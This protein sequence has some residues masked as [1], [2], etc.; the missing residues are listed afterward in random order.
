PQL[1]RQRHVHL[2]GGAEKV[3]GLVHAVIIRCTESRRRCKAYL[4]W[5]RSTA[6]LPVKLTLQ[7]RRCPMESEPTLSLKATPPR[8][9]LVA[10][11][12]WFLVYLASRFALEEMRLV[13]PW[14]WVATFAHLFAFF[15]FVSVVERALKSADELQ[16]LIQL[17]ALAM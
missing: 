15:W 11:A 4:T 7:A 3:A 6:T 2:A 12:T 9:V 10:G 14:A 16:R 1:L 13:A 8:R 5:R 17:E